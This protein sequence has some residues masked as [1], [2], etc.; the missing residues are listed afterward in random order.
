MIRSR[1]SR[2]RRLVSEFD[3]CPNTPAATATIPMAKTTPRFVLVAAD[4]SPL[5][6][7]G[8]K[9]RADSRRL[10][11]FKVSTR[12]NRT[13]LQ[14]IQIQSPEKNLR[15]FGLQN[16]LPGVRNRVRAFERFVAVDL[17]PDFVVVAQDLHPVP[18]AARLLDF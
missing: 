2:H 6:L 13:S 4:V 11:R 15:A 10:L 16:N 8:G 5:H 12:M 3:A 7:L 18:F 14:Q 1:A 9:V 17:D